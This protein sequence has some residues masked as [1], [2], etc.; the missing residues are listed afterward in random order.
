MQ[1]IISIDWEDWFHI[2]EVEHL[3]PKDKWD[4]YP[5]ILDEATDKILELLAAK[6]TKAT[7]FIVG[8][9]AQRQPELIKRI[10]DEGHEIAH[11]SMQHDLVYNLTPEHF[12]R[13][14]QEGQKLL[15]EMSGQQI[16]GFR[17]P[18]WSINKR[19]PWAADVLI[20]AGFAYDSSMAPMP[21]I[22]SMDFPQH[23]HIIKGD[24]VEGSLVEFPPLTLRFPGI[25][26]PGGGG[27]GLKIWPLRWIFNK[28]QKLN[29]AGSP[30]CFF[31]H[32]VDFVKHNYGKGLPLVKR[33]VTSYGIRSTKKICDFLFDRIELCPIKEILPGLAKQNNE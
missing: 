1:N 10:A 33:A 28:V 26:V 22:G 29:R 3:L 9:S 31:L 32:P 11:H 30:A 24:K 20:S 12:A 2:C 27:W 25:N 15:E 17:A 19:T 21:I 18:Q 7:F 16:M 13:D 4:S 23:A 6:K 8:Y 5:S 14:V